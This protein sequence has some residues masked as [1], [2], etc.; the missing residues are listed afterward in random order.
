MSFGA[1]K[2]WREVAA[3]LGRLARTGTGTRTHTGARDP[4]DFAHADA[5]WLTGR[6]ANS[7][8]QT[9]ASAGA[10]Q[11]TKAAGGGA[12]LRRPS[13]KRSWLSLEFEWELR[14]AFARAAQRASERENTTERNNSQQQQQQQQPGAGA[15]LDRIARAAP[16]VRLL[17]VAPGG[18]ARRLHYLARPLARNPRR[19]GR[20]H[21]NALLV[22][23]RQL[24][25]ARSRL[26]DDLETRA[27]AAGAPRLRSPPA[28][29][30]A[31]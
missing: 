27:G 7:A 21:S 8:R 28:A 20:T 29:R 16:R 22:E 1:A 30:L 17:I 12:R 3:G 31:R 13:G 6:L 18:L 9:R 19:A 15:A 11:E 26:A 4:I 10:E 23:Q 5:N 24:V 25:A 14:A 2:W